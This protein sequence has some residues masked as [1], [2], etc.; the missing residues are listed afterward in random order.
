MRGYLRE[1]DRRAANKRK[2][3]Q[4]SWQ[5]VVD[6]GFELIGDVRRRRQKVRPFFGTR[7]DAEDALRAFI[8]EIK[9]G[10]LVRD[11]KQTVAQFL[12]AWLGHKQATVG[13]K[14][15]LAYELHVRP[16]LKPTLGPLADY[17]PAKGT[18]A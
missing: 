13:F 6:D 8:Q 2:G 5:L 18:R 3:P 15:Y 17:E 16:Y 12:D 1:R 4:K 11:T 7:G 10:T 9:R 14:T